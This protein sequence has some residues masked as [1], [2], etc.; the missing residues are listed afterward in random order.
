MLKILQK[1]K[2]YV[3]IILA[4]LIVALAFWRATA[5]PEVCALCDGHK[6]HAPCVVNLST[7]EVGELVIYEPHH[8][9][10]GEIAEE[11]AGGTLV[12]FPCIGQRAVRDTDAETS[13]VELPESQE[14]MKPK[15]FC[16]SCRNL[17]HGMR[18]YALVDLYDLNHIRVFS[19]ADGAQYEIRDYSVCTAVNDQG[20]FVEVQGKVSASRAS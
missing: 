20:F 19:I 3:I 15:Y 2:V 1:N 4:V 18:R 9:L 11:Q 8:T 5:E 10:V 7:G 16:R 17:L 14:R 12:F 13:A 6:R